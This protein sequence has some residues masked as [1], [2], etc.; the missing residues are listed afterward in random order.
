M[1]IGVPFFLKC[2]VFDMMR[3][4][5]FKLIIPE[6]ETKSKLRYCIIHEVIDSGSEIS[7]NSVKLTNWTDISVELW[8]NFEATAL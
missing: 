1:F 8:L 6:G 3:L 4:H 7:R 2:I 5:T